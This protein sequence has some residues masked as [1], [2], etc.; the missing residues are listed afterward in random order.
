M[1]HSFSVSQI[2]MVS[3]GFNK[4]GTYR[5]QRQGILK[6]FWE[7]QCDAAALYWVLLGRCS[8]K[9]LL[10]LGVWIDWRQLVFTKD[11]ASNW[12]LAILNLTLVSPT[13]VLSK[14]TCCPGKT[15]LEMAEAHRDTTCLLGLWLGLAYRQFGTHPQTKQVIEEPS[16][17]QGVRHSAS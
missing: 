12:F 3:Q 14:L 13:D 16:Q 7:K 10:S 1:Y 5:L 9:C 11:S 2:R 8:P 6:N 4:G 15:L 17:G